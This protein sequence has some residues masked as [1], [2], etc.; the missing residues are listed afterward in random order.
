VVPVKL[1]AVTRPAR[2]FRVA[3]VRK[4]DERKCARLSAGILDINVVDAAEL[5]ED[6]LQLLA[7]HVIGQIPDKNSVAWGTTVAHGSK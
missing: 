2:V 4:L 5:A 6:I 3:V 7:A 1:H